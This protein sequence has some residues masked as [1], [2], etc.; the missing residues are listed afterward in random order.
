[1][2]VSLIYLLIAIAVLSFLIF[3]HEVGH[4]YTAK[5]VGMKVEA[6]SIG[7]GRPL[8]SWTYQ[9]VDWRLGWLP[10]GGYVKIASGEEEEGVDPYKVRDGFFGRPPL[11]RIKV[12]LAGPL[13]NLLFALLVFWGLWLAGG[14]VKTFSEFTS[15][16]GWVDPKSALYQEGLRPGDEVTYYGEQ[17]FQTANEHM[18]APMTSAQLRVRGYH[19]DQATGARTPFDL[20]VAP[21]PNPLMFDKELLTSGILQPASQLIF[22][23]KGQESGLAS[24]SPLNASG[25]QPGD[26]VVWANGESIF[27]PM[28][29]SHLINDGRALLT[30]QRNN[31][32]FLRRVPRVLVMDLKL[33]QQFREELIDWQYAAELN[34]EKIAKLYALPYNLTA[35]AV[36]E[37]A[38]KFIDAEQEQRAF[39]SSPQ[40]SLTEALQPG[41]RIIAVDGKPIQQAFELLE[42]LQEPHVLLIVQRGEANSVLELGEVNDQFA[43]INPEILQKIALSIGTDQ[44]LQTEGGLYLLNPVVPKIHREFTSNAGVT[45]RYQAELAERLAAIDAVESAEKRAF[46]H[47]K[48]EESENTLYLGPPYFIDRQVIYNPSPIQLFKDVVGDVWRTLKA[49]FSGNLNPKW[50]AGPIGIVQVVQENWKTSIQEGI[51]W[52]GAISINLG[53]LNLLPI[54]VLDGGSICFSLFEMIT[55]RQIKPKTMEKLIVPFAFLIIG[56]LVFLTYQDVLRLLGR[57]LKW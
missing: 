9:G 19:I 55:G 26:R 8:Y 44:Q 56:L 52:I 42:A 37:N 30:V 31:E 11:D 33:D 6:F 2:L 34:G 10:F 46:L 36:V 3:I 22:N 17:A 15:T 32:T 51:Y 41:D 50:L 39:P 13:V 14:R 53:M 43:K 23:P 7:M 18:I 4:Y 40:S 47:Q 54:P 49:L 48:L 57:F 38:L 16:V 20:T 27:S 12:S 1:M 5:R 25:I 21:Y 35:D 24:G 29:L 45:T 28:Q